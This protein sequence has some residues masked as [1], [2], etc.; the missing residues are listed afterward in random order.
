M[1]RLLDE[2]A[3]LVRIGI[4]R[5]AMYKKAK[6]LGFTHPLVVSCSQELDLLLNKYFEKAS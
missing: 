5:K 1:K 4:K 3:L 6:N 2:K